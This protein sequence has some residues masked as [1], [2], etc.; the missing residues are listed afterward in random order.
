MWLRGGKAQAEG[1]PAL[2]AGGIDTNLGGRDGGDVEVSTASTQ[3]SADEQITCQALQLAL[4]A[5][6]LRTAWHA[7]VMDADTAM[8]SLDRAVGELCRRRAGE[9]QPRSA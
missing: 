4:V 9:R 6:Q 2:S 5:T 8:R 7:G 3:T 1:V